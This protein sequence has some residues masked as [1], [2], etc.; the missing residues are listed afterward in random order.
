MEELLDL[1]GSVRPNHR[2]AYNFKNLYTQTIDN[3]LAPRT[4]EFRQHAGTK[5]PVAITMW[6]RVCGKLVE[7]A[8]SDFHGHVMSGTVQRAVIGSLNLGSFGP[9]EF[10]RELGA[11]DEAE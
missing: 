6:A 4:I 1:I 2:L 8:G 5:D 3:S 9:L 10:M 11:L 7:Y